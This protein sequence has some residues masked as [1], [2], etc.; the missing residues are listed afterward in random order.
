VCGVG[1]VVMGLGLEVWTACVRMSCVVI[2]GFVL[3]TC[4]RPV[5]GFAGK[6]YR[7]VCLPSCDS[8]PL[9]RP[10]CLPQQY[11]VSHLVG[12]SV[13]YLRGTC[14]S[15]WTWNMDSIGHG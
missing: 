9:T 2:G 4:T 5:G 12:L 1:G 3:H 13:R 8:S 14:T 6:P 7:L 11:N 10:M 15:C